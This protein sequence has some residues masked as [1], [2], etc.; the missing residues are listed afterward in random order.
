V[1][2]GGWGLSL[3]PVHATESPPVRRFAHRTGQ[4]RATYG[5]G[6]PE[7]ADHADGAG[8]QRGHQ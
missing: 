3:I 7:R 4:G 6:D 8:W 5:G 2:A 1:A